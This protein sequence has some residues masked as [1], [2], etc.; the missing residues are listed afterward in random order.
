VTP[1]TAMHT[2][3]LAVEKS[4]FAALAHAVLPAT[5]VRLLVFRD[6]QPIQSI[7]PEGNESQN[8]HVLETCRG[9]GEL[10]WLLTRRCLYVLAEL[11]RRPLVFNI[12]HEL[13][14]VTSSTDS[15]VKSA[16]SLESGDLAYFFFNG[17]NS[18]WIY[19]Y[20][21]HELIPVVEL[22]GHVYGACEQAGQVYAVGE[23]FLEIEGKIETKPL[24]WDLSS[25]RAFEHQGVDRTMRH[26]VETTQTSQLPAGYR[27]DRM[28]VD[29]FVACDY[30]PDGKVLLQ[31]FISEAVFPQDLDWDDSVRGP[32]PSFYD[33]IGLA[34]FEFDG[35]TLSLL[36]VDVHSRLVEVLA[37]AGACQVYTFKGKHAKTPTLD[38][39]YRQPLVLAGSGE[40]GS[41]KLVFDG[42][43][44]DSAFN[45][46]RIVCRTQGAY[47]AVLNI[48]SE[49]L[50]G[51]FSPEDFF[52]TSTD[53]LTWLFV[54]STKDLTPHQVALAA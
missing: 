34:Y 22:A 51:K 11:G 13:L 29:A 53:G 21:S 47:F 2:D 15:A 12:P 24:L 43:A 7:E 1:L 20:E 23:Q 40:T 38:A 19:R 3:L 10:H 9:G 49:F 52:F 54:G 5:N 45:S 31:A 50:A 48:S 32:T 26:L 36:R 18:C 28:H 25:G 14:N 39:L 35:N 37:Q 33:C 44:S 46:L 30:R 4:Y 6:G 42:V 27:T 16:L 8:F 41:Q 17:T